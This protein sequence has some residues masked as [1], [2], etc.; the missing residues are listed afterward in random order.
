MKRK[1]IGI[2]ASAALL[3]IF[4]LL[5]GT[6]SAAAERRTL[7]IGSGE[8]RGYYYP[9]A[10]ALCRIL[11]KD[12]PKGMACA[13]VPSSGTTANVAGLKSGETDLALVQSRSLTLALEGKD[14]GL[15]DLR[16]VMALHGE[17][18][19][20]LV[21]PESELASLENLKGKR[22]NVG[23][24]GS[25]QR[26]VTEAVI[27]VAGLSIA[28]F[29]PAVELELEEQVKELCAGN[30]DAAFFTGVHPMPEVIS[31]M[32]TCDAIPLLV[33]GKNLEG[34]LK[35]LPWLSESTI[36][37]GTYEEIKEDL[38][39]LQLRT[40]LVATTRLSADDVQA[41]LTALHANFSSLTKLHPVLDKFS[42]KESI[43]GSVP[44]PLHDGA[45]AFYATIA[46]KT[47]ARPPTASSPAA[48]TP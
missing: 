5:M 4:P 39:S 12:H 9:A 8:V 11:N 2:V 44:L 23:R 7:L 27:S 17:S 40:L 25:F 47:E 32:E 3:L 24:P 35:K 19:L 6:P 13:V 26:G 41:I 37:R 15:G 33:Q 10:G 22:V 38:P 48:A 1:P 29:S 45:S 31:A 43:P 46:S 36:R 20:V 18:V 21:R 42:K 30:I 34:A 16:T 28:D 14:A